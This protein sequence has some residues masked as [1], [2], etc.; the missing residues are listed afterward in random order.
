MV[1]FDKLYQ[2]KMN[3]KFKS[4]IVLSTVLIIALVFKSCNKD[5]N[6]NAEWEDI[7]VVFG[8]LDQN[9]DTQ[10]VKINKAFLGEADAFDMAQVRDSSEYQNIEA[11]IEE[12]IDN[13]KLGVFNLVKYE[14]TNKEPGV[15]YAPNQTVYYFTKPTRLDSS[16]KYKLIVKI[17]PGTANEKILSAETELIDGFSFGSNYRRWTDNGS[18]KI[19]IE[20]ATTTEIEDRDF[21]IN[22]QPDAKRYEVYGIFNY[23]DV[24]VSGSG[25][26]TRPM[27]FEFRLGEY[28]AK[29]TDGGQEIIVALSGEQFLQEVGKNVPTVD[30]TDVE[31]VKRVVGDGSFQ[32]KVVAAGEDL[33]TYMEVNEP[34]TGIVQEKKEFTNV[35][36]GIGIFSARSSIIGSLKLGEKT[37]KELMT[38][39]LSSELADDGIGYTVGRKFL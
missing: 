7:T 12:W 4:I 34:T 5:I 21:K 37:I 19:A 36:N 3:R 20:F 31:I 17:N 11:T 24:Y 2:E 8:L 30:N 32:L 6:V 14:V 1:I 18:G 27:S 33:N 29:N 39:S 35:T 26:A 23:E 13:Q 22:T 16:A 9:V 25:T 38:G 10:F 15:F 28:K